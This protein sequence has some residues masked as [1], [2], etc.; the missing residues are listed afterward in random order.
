MNLP[1]SGSNHC[2][3]YDTAELD[4]SVDMQIAAVRLKV[5]KAGWWKA[6]SRHV[7]IERF[8]AAEQQ[9]PTHPIVDTLWCGPPRPEPL[10]P[11]AEANKSGRGLSSDQLLMN[12]D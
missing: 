2:Y 5:K 12:K 9:L 3:S 7:N 10:V 6:L 11:A 1:C 8:N 4:G